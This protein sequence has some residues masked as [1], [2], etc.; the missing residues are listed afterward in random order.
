MYGNNYSGAVVKRVRG[1][2]KGYE[3]ESYTRHD[4]NTIDEDGNGKPPQKSTFLEKSQSLV[5]AKLEIEYQRS[6]L[7]NNALKKRKNEVKNSFKRSKNKSN[8]DDN[9]LL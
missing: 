8:N 2:H 5:S 9:N 3:F 7:S 6:I 1:C 4:E